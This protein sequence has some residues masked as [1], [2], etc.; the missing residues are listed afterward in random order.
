M[1]DISYYTDYR[2]LLKDFYEDC[3]KK[4]PWF[5]YQC[6][7]QRAGIS[8]RGLLFNVVSGRRRL[9]PSHI[10]GVAAAMKLS[11]SQFEY[12]ENLVAYNNSRTIND[13]QRFFERMTSIK[14]AGKNGLQPQLVR[15]EQYSFYSQWYHP[16]V[17]SLIDLYGFD[18]DFK[19]L[20]QKVTPSITPTQARKSVELLESLGFIKKNSD[21]SYHV[22]D[23]I[24]SSARE[25]ISLAI[26]NYHTQTAEIAKN[27]LAILPRNRRNFSGVTLG[28][29][30]SSYA[31][32]C[33]ELEDF[34]DRLLE[35]AHHDSIDCDEHGVYQLNLQLFSVSEPALLSAQGQA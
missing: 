3:K 4:N 23:K 27:A 5:S 18:G 29:S 21:N 10:A 14:V 2:T 28:I 35:L 25:V 19:Q 20:A 8:S 24:I 16:V 30:A 6:F 32:V 17:R 33:K 15:K 31:K 7:C 9:S 1:N 26:H 34:R 12:F 11:K 13:K 22:V